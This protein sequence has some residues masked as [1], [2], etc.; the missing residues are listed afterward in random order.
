MAAKLPTNSSTA[1]AARFSFKTGHHVAK[2]RL[3]FSGGRRL[4]TN[5]GAVYDG[6]ARHM[7]EWKE[8]RRRRR[9]WA[10]SFK[11]M[12]LGIIIIIITAA[13]THQE[14]EGSSVEGRERRASG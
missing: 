14:D 13:T 6:T 12:S 10:G 1:A 5:C 4:I 9:Q 2:G 8:R 3:F 11:C 7:C